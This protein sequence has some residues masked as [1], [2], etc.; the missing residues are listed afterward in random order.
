MLCFG[1]PAFAQN[2]ADLS[3]GGV[4]RINTP[5]SNEFFAESYRAAVA[6]RVCTLATRA[7]KAIK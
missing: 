7:D 1:A 6:A 3:L 2:T 5:E 4:L